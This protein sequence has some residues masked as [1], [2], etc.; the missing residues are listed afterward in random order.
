MM[1]TYTRILII[2]FLVLW[3]ERSL[4]LKAFPYS[5]HFLLASSFEEFPPHPGSILRELHLP[6]QLDDKPAYYQREQVQLI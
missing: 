3:H 6:P 2:L 1:N 5:S 4:G